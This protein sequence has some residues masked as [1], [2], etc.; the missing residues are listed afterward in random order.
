MT[1]VGDRVTYRDRTAIVVTVHSNGSVNLVY[2][3]PHSEDADGIWPVA[4]AANVPRDRFD[5]I[6]DQSGTEDD[7][8][9]DAPDTGDD[10]DGGGDVDTQGDVV[11]KDYDSADDFV[12]RTPVSDVASD[13]RSG[14]YDDV[15]DAI[16][17]AEEAGADR[18][19][20]YDAIA[21]RR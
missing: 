6:D 10:G 15:L 3:T 8:A 2:G 18:D 19:T 4:N 13:I 1:Q 5:P 9:D 21:S 11:I 14:D 17:A 20:V 12:D 16:E 7:E